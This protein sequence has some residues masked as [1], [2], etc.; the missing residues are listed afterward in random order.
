MVNN[1][2]NTVLVYLC[3]LYWDTWWFGVFIHNTHTHTCSESIQPSWDIVESAWF[4]EFHMTY[5]RF[6]LNLQLTWG[7][8]AGKREECSFKGKNLEVRGV[9][10]PTPAKHQR[11]KMLQKNSSVQYNVLKAYSLL[12]NVSLWFSTRGDKV[13]TEFCVDKRFHQLQI[14]SSSVHAHWGI[15]LFLCTASFS[16]FVCYLVVMPAVVSLGDKSR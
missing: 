3:C 1:N 11:M 9:F 2:N 12:W 14:D 8:P 15:A 16:V 10:F 7:T 6:L 5:S 4:P 13:S